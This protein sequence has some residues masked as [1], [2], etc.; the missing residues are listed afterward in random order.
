VDQATG[1][2]K[3]M[4]TAIWDVNGFHLLDLVPSQCKLNAQYFV[5]YVLVPM[6]Q[7]V[8]PQG[9]ARYTLRLNVHLDNCRVH[10]STVTKQF[11]IENQLL[12]VPH[13][14]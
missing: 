10:F 8:F 5:E 4:L 3:F 13:S 12:D 14:A 6:V 9:K 1:T 2:A 11:F 7:A